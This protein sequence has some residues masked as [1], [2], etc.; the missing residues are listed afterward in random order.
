MVSAPG[1]S[2]SAKWTLAGFEADRAAIGNPQCAEWHASDADSLPRGSDRPR[3]SPERRTH[4]RRVSGEHHIE[5][6]AEPLAVSLASTDRMLQPRGE[7]KEPPRPDTRHHHVGVLGGEGGNRQ[8]DDGRPHARVTEI[9]GVRAW[10][11]ADILD[12]AQEVFRMAV[13]RVRRTC[14]VELGRASGDP[15]TRM[16]DLFNG[17]NPLNRVMGTIDEA[18]QRRAYM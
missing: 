15:K 17:E 8:A 6:D 12:P 9:D 10:R 4:G 11:G 16:P 5:A 14:G 13:D 3:A 7:D 18:G 1:R 2:L